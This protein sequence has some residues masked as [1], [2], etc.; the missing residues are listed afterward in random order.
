MR[1][2]S[3]P[4]KPVVPSTKDD[5]IAGLIA[6]LSGADARARESAACEIFL[7]GFA[8]V[9]AVADEWFR[10]GEIANCFV[11]DDAIARTT[12][13]R[14]TV[15]IAVEPEVFDRIRAANGSPRLADVP[16][17]LDA[18][19]FEL[20]GGQ[21]ARLDVLTTRDANG[22]GAIARFLQKHGAGIQQVEL[23][24]RDVE[25]A[26][27]L[28]RVRF[29]LASIYVKPRAGADGTRV[30]FFLVSG[31]DHRKVLI[32]LVQMPRAR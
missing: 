26:T 4:D 30:N 16:S 19:E 2:M 12:F 23:E 14:T 18:K 7:R 3:L 32:E 24:V 5:S 11:F 25:R 15:G 8:R 20:H 29:G 10:D 28:L 6:Q 1:R 17:D 9:T 13:P 21:D 27:E 31:R 22:D